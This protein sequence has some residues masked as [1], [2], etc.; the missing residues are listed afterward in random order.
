MNYCEKHS[1]E[2]QTANLL[3]QRNIPVTFVQST[4]LEPEAV[5]TPSPEQVKPS[6]DALHPPVKA[7][8]NSH[9]RKA[10]QPKKTP[11]AGKS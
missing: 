5:P 8:K 10:S 11:A 4:T 6:G 7:S 9:G 1:K 2:L 3:V